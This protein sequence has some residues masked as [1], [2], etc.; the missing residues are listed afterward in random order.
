MS[1]F[2]QWIASIEAAHDTN[3]ELEH[4]TPG[5]MHASLEHRAA[6]KAAWEAGHEVALHA[7]I[8]GHKIEA[9]PLFVDLDE[10]HGFCQ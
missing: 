6:L 1:T 8:G 3:A 5:L 9:T 10:K 4:A 2:E 7:R